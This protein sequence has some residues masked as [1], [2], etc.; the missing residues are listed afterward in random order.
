VLERIFEIMESTPAKLVAEVAPLTDAELRAKPRPHC[1][2]IVEVIGH[3]DD[4]EEGAMRSRV[5]AIVEAD[6]PILQSFDQTGRAQEMRYID[7][8]LAS[9]LASFTKQRRHNVAWLKTL[10]TKTLTRVGVH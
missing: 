5:A 8:N 9:A 7:K 3:L 10:A 1:W 2:S 4:A 6:H